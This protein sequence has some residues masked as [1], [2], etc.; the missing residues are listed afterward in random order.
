M[1]ICIF[2]KLGILDDMFTTTFNRFKLKVNETFRLI[3]N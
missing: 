3:I 2:R 1:N